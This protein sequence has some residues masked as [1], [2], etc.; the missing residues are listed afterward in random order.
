MTAALDF[1]C[2]Q[3]A[4]PFECPDALVVHHEAFGEYG[5]VVHDGGP[6]YVLIRHCP[7]CGEDLGPSWRDQ[8][9]DALEALGIT[10]P[11]TSNL[12]PEFLTSAWR[13]SP[14]KEA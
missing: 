10:S 12:P 13:R 9:F 14:A 3:H 6:S 8:W 5:I 7:W 2:D 4:D 11:R 1:S